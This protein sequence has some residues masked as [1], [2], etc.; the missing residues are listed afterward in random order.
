MRK[1][2]KGA[3]QLCSNYVADQNLCSCNSLDSTTTFLAFFFDY[4]GRFVSD[5][6]GNPKERFFLHHGSI[7]TGKDRPQT[8]TIE[9]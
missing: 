6:L 4:T 5:L 7:H 9:K 2:N 8:G 1:P 3:D